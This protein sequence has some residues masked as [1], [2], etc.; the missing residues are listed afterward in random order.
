MSLTVICNSVGCSPKLL[1]AQTSASICSG[2]QHKHVG[3]SQRDGWHLWYHAER[4]LLA[5][6]SGGNE[7]L[8]ASLS[9]GKTCFTVL[10]VLSCCIFQ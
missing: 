6:L 1:S 9:D 2:R 3:R 5:W 4:V 10:A 7:G 8:V